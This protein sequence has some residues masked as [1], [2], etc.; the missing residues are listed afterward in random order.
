MKQKRT[1][2]IICI[3]FALMTG[4]VS[5]DAGAGIPGNTTSAMDGADNWED[6]ADQEQSPGSEA[7]DGDASESAGPNTTDEA[8]SLPEVP[9]R[10]SPDP[11]E[12]LHASILSSFSTEYV[13]WTFDSS[14]GRIIISL[15]DGTEV[16]YPLS[17]EAAQA[18]SQSYDEEYYREAIHCIADGNRIMLFVP[19]FAGDAAVACSED[20]GVTWQEYLIPDTYGTD[21]TGGY[22]GDI[23]GGG[24][25]L[26]VRG[27][28]GL[29]RVLHTLYCKAPDGEFVRYDAFDSIEQRELDYVT[30]LSEDEAFI[31]VGVG[32]NGRYPFLYHST[33]GGKTWAE[34][35]FLSEQEDAFVGVDR[36]EIVDGA[37]EMIC[38]LRTEEDAGPE[39]YVSDDG[40]VW[41]AR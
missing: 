7:A 23:P 36:I 33:D 18:A 11:E 3:L 37:F 40:F 8:E 32:W 30:F 2:I 16:A 5:K 9:S 19:P 38:S 41:D 15:S 34:C 29:G 21:V 27:T 4:C 6:S 28:I 22:L 13:R 14:V 12:A 25:W 39:V 1:A 26:V 17:E 31:S 35:T 24:T 20:G 10:E